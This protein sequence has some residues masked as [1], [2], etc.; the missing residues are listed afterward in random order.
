MKYLQVTVKCKFRVTNAT[1]LPK[2]IVHVAH[3]V[4]F[5][6]RNYWS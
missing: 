4:S 5:R 3:K 1:F 2:F 6:Q